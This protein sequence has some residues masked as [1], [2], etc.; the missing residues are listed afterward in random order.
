MDLTLNVGDYI[1]NIRAAAI[2]IHNNK[3]LFHKNLNKEHYALIGGRIGIGE[4]SKDTVKREVFEELGKEI[5]IIKHMAT[6]ENFFKANGKKY[7]EILFVY[8]A[9]FTNDKDKLIETE[10]KHAE[11]KE[12]LKY[13]WLDLDKI[14]E[15]NIVPK[16]IKQV[17][18]NITTESHIINNELK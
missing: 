14:E 3:V 6:I 8:N 10:M 15:Y 4:S 11:G 16:A 9:E 5:N 17:L 12:Y 13:E 18:Q 1:L 7:H 2:I